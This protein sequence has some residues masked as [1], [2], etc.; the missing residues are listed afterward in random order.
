MAIIRTYS[1]LLIELEKAK[2]IA[3][4]KSA[5]KTV[6]LVKVE[7]NKEVYSEPEGDYQRTY[8]LRESV[9]D[10]PL[11]I[12]GRASEIK[13]AHDTGQIVSNASVFQ[14][15]SNYWSPSD[16][17]EYL[18]ETIHGG[19]SGSLFGTNKHW[20]KPKPYMDNAK[21]EMLNGQYRKF[22]MESL[23]RSG[24]NVI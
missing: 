21:A 4:A 12:K 11:E 18:A 6:E 7:I 13:I 2:N 19:L 16:Y 14:H 8:Q 15:G 9:K 5:E 22:M 24:Y 1:Q 17:S 23:M 20:H 10:F 3:L